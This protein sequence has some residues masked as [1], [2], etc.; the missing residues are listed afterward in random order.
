MFSQVT[1]VGKYHPY[2][3]WEAW[4]E[5][6]SYFL[7]VRATDISIHVPKLLQF[8]SVFFLSLQE[9]GREKEGREGGREGGKEGRREG[10]G[11]R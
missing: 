10:G 3:I 7:C 6:V 2:G 8:G 1:E 4:T 5:C 11:N 9:G